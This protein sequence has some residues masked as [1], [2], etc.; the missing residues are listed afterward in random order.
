MCLDTCFFKESGKIW[1]E[2]IS[3]FSFSCSWGGQN[4]S[5]EA[6]LCSEARLCYYEPWVLW[7]LWACGT[8]G[9][10]VCWTSP[11][12]SSNLRCVDNPELLSSSCHLRELSA[13]PCDHSSALL[14]L[15]HQCWS[16]AFSWFGCSWAQQL[17]PLPGFS[18]LPSPAASCNPHCDGL[19]GMV[20]LGSSLM[21]LPWTEKSWLFRAGCIHLVLVL[22]SFSTAAC[23][24]NEFVS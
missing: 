20:I 6:V 15:E 1:V 24:A 9:R 13:A 12:T 23:A 17:W 4:L 5:L 8:G 7:S 19:P 3:K 2:K 11:V 22:L 10:G 21:V 16:P 18:F 14:F